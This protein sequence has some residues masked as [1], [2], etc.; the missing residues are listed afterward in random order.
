MSAAG[1]HEILL[2]GDYRL[3]KQ[4]FL[5]KLIATEPMTRHL[6]LLEASLE[7]EKC[8]IHSEPVEDK[9]SRFLEEGCVGLCCLTVGLM[10]YD[11]F[12]Y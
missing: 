7:H 2:G 9:T 10:A 8:Y 3:E 4:R 6:L 5:E 1:Q 12:L 11:Q